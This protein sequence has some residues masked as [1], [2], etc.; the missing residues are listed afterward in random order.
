[1]NMM[2]W[3]L[4]VVAALLYGASGIMKVFMF[5]K[6]GRGSRPL[7]RCRGKLAWPSASP[8]SSGQSA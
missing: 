1:M 4:Q 7:A 3:V 6:V 2:L 8:N 5:D